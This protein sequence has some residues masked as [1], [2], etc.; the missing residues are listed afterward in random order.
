MT[1]SL[2]QYISDVKSE[3][4][5]LENEI[6]FYLNEIKLSNERIDLYLNRDLDTFQKNKLNEFKT[7]NIQLSEDIKAIYQEIDSFD[8]SLLHESNNTKVCEDTFEKYHSFKEKLD[9][10]IN[11]YMDVKDQ[12]VR[13]SISALR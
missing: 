3:I 12:L 13:F 4:R 8:D 2:L 10:V 6:T 7:T 1:I 9:E 11:R 5:F